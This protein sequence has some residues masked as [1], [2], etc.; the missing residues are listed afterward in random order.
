MRF[1][2]RGI[3]IDTAN[4]TV[5]VIDF[6]GDY[7]EIQKEINVDCF[8]CVDID[9]KNTI[10]VDDEGMLKENDFFMIEGYPEPLAGNGLILAV[11]YETGETVGTEMEV[12]EIKF[13]SRFEIALMAKAMGLCEVLTVVFIVLKLTNHIAWSWF[14]VLSPMLPAMLLYAGLIGFQVYLVNKMKG[15]RNRSRKRV[16]N[17]E[18]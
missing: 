5:E 11:D 15:L 9:D 16:L 12:P 2:M 1:K 14:L 10:F 17:R 4:R 6:E 13:L 3:K 7:V 18:F 8:T